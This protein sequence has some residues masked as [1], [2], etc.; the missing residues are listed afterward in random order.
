[1]DDVGYLEGLLGRW[2]KDYGRAAKD[3]RLNRKQWT[4]AQI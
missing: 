1:V 3:V 4:A 2:G